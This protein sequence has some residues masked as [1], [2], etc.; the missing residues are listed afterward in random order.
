MKLVATAFR[1]LTAGHLLLAVVLV[2][3]AWMIATAQD[4]PAEAAAAPGLKIAVIDLQRV[5]ENH[6]AFKAGREV[7]TEETKELQREALAKRSELE[8]QGEPLKKM[9]PGSPEFNELR[10][11]LQ[12][13]A[14]DFQDQYTRKVQ[15]QAMKES[16]LYE[17][18]YENISSEVEQ[19]AQARGIPLVLQRNNKF[20]DSLKSGKERSAQDII[21]GLNQTV[22]YQSGLDITDDIIQAVN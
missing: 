10:D 1:G 12:S 3:S 11:K 9:K 5:Y 14:R 20:S 19:L 8:T 22:I 21:S 15:A 6:P 16:Q 4:G 13:Q 2:C 18:T 17:K 7:L